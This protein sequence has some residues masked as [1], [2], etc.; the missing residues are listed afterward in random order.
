MN[1]LLEAEINDLHANICGGLADPK[2][3]IILYSLA[4]RP[5]TVNE[6]AAAVHLPQP[7]VSRHLRVLRERGMVLATRQGQS[8][9]YRLAD[10]RLIQALD[11]LRAVLRDNLAHRANLAESLN[12]LNEL[13]EE[14]AP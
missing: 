5:Q 11:I 9:G 2:R 4:D 7:S 14:V 8:V 6:L 1:E 3:I 12:V 13:A 10:G